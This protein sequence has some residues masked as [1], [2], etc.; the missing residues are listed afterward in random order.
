VTAARFE[1][2]V[3]PRAEAEIAFNQF[4]ADNE[5]LFSSRIM[6]IDVWP[7]SASRNID[8]PHSNSRGTRKIPAITT[9]PHFNW[10]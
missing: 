7:F 5:K 1:E 8:H 2:D 3:G 9:I 4:T 10:R 6:F